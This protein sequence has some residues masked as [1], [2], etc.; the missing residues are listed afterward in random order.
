MR[1]EMHKVCICVYRQEQVSYK[2]QFKGK[3]KVSILA[4]SKFLECCIGHLCTSC[5]MSSS[6]IKACIGTI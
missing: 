5:S 3:K 1:N 4:A 2:N 6:D